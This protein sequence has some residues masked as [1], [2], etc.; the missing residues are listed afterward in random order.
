MPCPLRQDAI[1]VELRA[2]SVV[3]DTAGHDKL[4]RSQLAVIRA[5]RDTGYTISPGAAGRDCA[6]AARY[7]RVVFQGQTV[8]PR[9]SRCHLP[10][11]WMARSIMSLQMPPTQNTSRTV[12]FGQHLW[13]HGSCTDSTGCQSPKSSARMPKVVRTVRTS[14]WTCSWGGG[15]IPASPGRV[16][17]LSPGGPR[18]TVGDTA[19]RQNVAARGATAAPDLGNGRPEPAA[20]CAAVALKIGG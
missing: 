12:N 7:G 2:G 1:H 8:L 13:T 16:R 18:P 19:R 11:G 6:D 9:S 17:N 4:S 14:T 5:I 15:P 20:C 3:I 10:S